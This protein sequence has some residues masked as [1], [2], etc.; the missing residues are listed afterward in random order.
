MAAS[1][2]PYRVLLTD[3]AWPDAQIEREILA[4]VGAE[5]IEAADTSEAA[6]C[7]LA[8]NVD[9]IATN[10]AHV[11]ETVVRA[12]S[13]CRVICRTGIGLDNIAVTAATE[14]G[15]PVTNVPDYCVAEVADHALA[16]ILACA[17]NIAFFHLRTKRGEYALQAGPAMPRLAGK[18]L[19]LVGL[20]H[21]GRNLAAKAQALGMEVVGHTSSGN[22]YG[23]GCRMASLDVLLAECDFVSLHAPLTPQTRHLL[24]L[25][26]FEKMKRSAY[27][28]NTARGGLIDHVGLWQALE[29]NLIAGAALDVFDP[30]PPDLSSPLMQDERVIVTPHA[31]FVSH[32]SLIELRTRVAQQIVDVLSGR[33]PECVV[34]PEVYARA[35]PPAG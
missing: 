23:T 29:K 31:A 14:L 22:D 11:T 30:E 33:R 25:A 8:A 12:A 2:A 16:L 15:I 32:E 18:R 27:L 20:G 24:G 5:L 7:R 26:Q 6:L 3:R 10:W 4:Q 34:N 28:I 17:R 35:D 13:R 21:I 9:A 19:G 1:P